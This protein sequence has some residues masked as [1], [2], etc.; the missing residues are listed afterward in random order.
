MDII[1]VNYTLIKA[2][3]LAKGLKYYY[4]QLYEADGTTTSGYNIF[5]TSPFYGL[6][7]TITSGSDITDFEANIKP[8]ATAVGDESEAVARSEFAQ[9]LSMILPGNNSGR[10]FGY[11]ATSAA[12][13]KTVRATTYTPQGT[14]S[15]RSFNSTNANDTGAGTGARKV[16]I[17]YLNASG[18]GPFTETV[19]LNGTARVNTVATDIALIERMDVVEV[20]SGG[21]NAGTIQIHTTPTSGGAVWGSIAIGDNQTYW[22]H[23]YVPPGKTCYVTNIEGASSPTIGGL[24]LN[25]ANPLSSLIPQRAPDITV[26][27]TNVHVFRQ[28]TIPVPV[29]GPAIIFVN[30]RPDAATASTVFASF[31]WIQT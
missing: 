29:V 9:L 11:T 22:A 16:K 18:A 5:A 4:T 6:A 26:R 12:T 23:H 27:H 21:G 8:T 25:T 30:E 31:G 1:Q 10:A 3:A 28:Y 15:Q 24:T 14:D 7:T 19:T 17:T 13:S 20:G 2:E